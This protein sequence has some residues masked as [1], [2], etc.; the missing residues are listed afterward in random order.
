MF[1]EDVVIDF[2]CGQF[3]EIGGI[4]LDKSDPLVYDLTVEI[5]FAWSVRFDFNEY[6]VVKFLLFSQLRS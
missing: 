2:I 4:W 3:V 1:I 6:C 5:E